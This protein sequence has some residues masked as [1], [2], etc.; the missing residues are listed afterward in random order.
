MAFAARLPRPEPTLSETAFIL[1]HAGY[2]EEAL[3]CTHL[4]KEIDSDE[5]VV[6]GLS[7]KT[8][9]PNKRTLLMAASQTGHAKRARRLLDCGADVNARD[10]RGVTALH[11]ACS[12]GHQGVAHLLL[13]HGADI[14]ARSNDGYE[15]YLMPGAGMDRDISPLHLASAGGR[16][17]LV[18]PLLDHGAEVN[19]RDSHNRSI[20][21]L[22]SCSSTTVR[23]STRSITTAARLSN[24]V[25]SSFTRA[26][27]RPLK[28][29]LTVVPLEML[30]CCTGAFCMGRTLLWTHSLTEAWT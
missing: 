30:H 3:T 7:R 6:E 13:D 10:T 16:W 22:L 5:R 29:C 15:I 27:R 26:T 11:A 28:C 1:A 19:A 21:R 4:C 8:F 12:E 14:N 24:S 25:V 17:A 20:N 23:T 18:G 2:T 9:G